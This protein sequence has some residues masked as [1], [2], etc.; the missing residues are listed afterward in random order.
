MARAT[1]NLGI[2]GHVDAGKTTLTERLLFAAGIIDEIG[3]VDDGTTQTDS[4]ALER[5][6][7]ITIK[8][9]V[10]SFQID[11]VIVNL[12][13]TPGHPDFIAEVDRALSVLDGAVLLISAVEGVQPQTR[14]L[15][16]VLQRLR[17]PTIMFVN[18]VDCLGARYERVLEEV[19]RRLTPRVVAMGFVRNQGTRIAASEA[20]DDADAATAARLADALAEHDDSISDAYLTS[21]VRASVPRL[22]EQLAFQT[23]SSLLHPVFIGSALTGTG[24]NDLMRGIAEFLPVVPG[25][26]GGLAA[27]RVFKVERGPGGEKIAVARMFSGTLRVRDRVSFGPND[28]ERKVTGV[29]VYTSGSAERRLA[30][31]AGEIARLHGLTEIRIG[32]H[33]GPAGQSN[34]IATL[35]GTATEFV[36][37][38]LE[39]IVT[40]CDARQ[41]GALREALG[42]LA[43][44]DPLI[45]VRQDDDRREISLS[46]YG[47]VQKEVIGATLAA[48]FGIDVDFRDSTTI[49]V[50]RPVGTGMAVERLKEPSNP[51]VATVGLR[52]DPARPGSGVAFGIEVELGSMPLAFFKAVE[53]TVRATLHQGLFG[54]EVIDCTVSMTHSGY[55]GKHSIGHARFTKSISSTGEDYRKLTPLVLMAALRQA[56]TVVC[57]PI[58]RFRLDAPIDVIGSL[59]PAL[60]RL[61]GIL[62]TQV[63]DGDASTVTGE[64]PAGRVHQLRQ[65]LP[66]WT[67]GEGVLECVFERYEPLRGAFPRRPRSGPDPLD[68]EEYLLRVSRQAHGMG[69]PGSNGNAD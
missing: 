7:G 4:L 33:I 26:A 8:S 49:C 31:S 20:W 17:L 32:D 68:R 2:L 58:N 48:D 29:E 38:T 63:T 19:A 67:R 14:I 39:T 45:G 18:K 64:I 12:I 56:G 59:L 35:A 65:R 55:L 25:D 22:R 36:P 54:W 6:R 61:R 30:A 3:S 10:V 66:A 60:A 57:E 44:Q 50:E 51:F 34:A 47:E 27:G 11:D 43:E 21:D 37:P 9:A 52:I 46:L 40:P 24:T 42:Q 13:D 53:D 16:R 1:L 41:R 23:C 62:L 5:Q 15:M 69:V 28:S